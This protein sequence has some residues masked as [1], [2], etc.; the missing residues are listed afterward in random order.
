MKDDRIR[1]TIAGCT[2][3]ASR[4]AVAPKR[5]WGS[6][7]GACAMEPQPAVVQKCVRRVT[8]RVIQAPPEALSMPMRRAGESFW[9][10]QASHPERSEGAMPCVMAPVQG[11]DG[12]GRP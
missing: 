10:K 3:H 9:A 8:R 4:R 2:H 7:W 6:G 11:D 12:R 5:A 1:N